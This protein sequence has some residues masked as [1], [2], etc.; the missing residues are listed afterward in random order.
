MSLATDQGKTEMDEVTLADHYKHWKRA[1]TTY[2]PLSLAGSVYAP[3]LS[4]IP[5]NVVTPSAM[6]A[7]FAGSRGT[8]QRNHVPTA[9]PM[10]YVNPRR[11]IW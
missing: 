3:S 1:S 6:V 10:C 7:L 11:L 8:K 5:S 4:L 9:E 2:E